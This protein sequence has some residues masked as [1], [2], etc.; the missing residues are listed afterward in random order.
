MHTQIAIFAKKRTDRVS[1]WAVKVKFGGEFRHRVHG[2][3]R[4]IALSNSSVVSVTSEAIFREG[5]A[6]DRL[7]IF[8][9]AVSD[10]FVQ[11]FK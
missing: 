11:F 2:E 8:D 7:S 3:H 10:H 4:E 5:Y 6:N 1:K 9:V